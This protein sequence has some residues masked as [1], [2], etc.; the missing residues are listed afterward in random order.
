MKLWKIAIPLF[1]RLL[2]WNAINLVVLLLAFFLALRAE[3]GPRIGGL[4]P[5]NSHPLTQAMALLLIHDLA[6]NPK[7]E[8]NPILSRVGVA[9]NIDLC[10]YDEQGHQVAGTPITLPGKIHT[11]VMFSHHD[12]EPLRP[13]LLS[14]LFPPHPPPRPDFAPNNHPHAADHGPDQTDPNLDPFGHQINP[15][16]DRVIPEFPQSVEF[17]EAPLQY[18]LLVFFPSIVWHQTFSPS[19]SLVTL[20]RSINL[21][22]L[23]IRSR[24][25]GW[26]V[27]WLSSQS[28]F[29]FR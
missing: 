28:R 3:Y 26:R 7:T 24:G 20:L 6:T 11:I 5:D 1:P 13:G 18:W 15:P 22:S 8:W 25:C 12:E 23:I 10:L 17:T 19:F 27:E 4:I 9:Y 16:A 2:I 21:R 14:F 29:G